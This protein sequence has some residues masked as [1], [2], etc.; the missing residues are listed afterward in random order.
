L[1]FRA[2]VWDG[3]EHG[4]EDVVH[5]GARF[6]VKLERTEDDRDQVSH[7]FALD[8]DVT[9]IDCGVETTRTP[10]DRPQTSV[11]VTVAGVSFP[12]HGA[13][14]RFSDFM[15][16]DLTLTSAPSDC[17][18]DARGGDLRMA[19]WLG[20][21]DGPHASLDGGRFAEHRS[22][23]LAKSPV[24][25]LRRAGSDVIVDLDGSFDVEGFPV[26]VAGTVT[27]LVCVP[28]D[29]GPFPFP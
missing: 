26:H 18:W 3:G 2:H 4:D 12:I 19:L 24:V 29:A 9:P 5:D 16:H 14:L 13:T 28:P 7:H 20:R 15:L 21:S 23:T 11:S 17:D 10:A 8:A 6:S 27:A 1:F 25:K 22:A